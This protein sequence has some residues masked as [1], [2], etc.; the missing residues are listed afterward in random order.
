MKIIKNDYGDLKRRLWRFKA[1]TAISILFFLFNFLNFFSFLNCSYAVVPHLINYQGKLTDPTGKPVVDNTYS[2]TFKIYDNSA[3]NNPLWT[4][5]QSVP[6][7]KGIFSVMLGGVTPLNLTFEKQYYLG[8][9]V[10]QDAEMRPLQQLT[11]S[12]YA[13]RAE[14]ADNA[15]Q[16]QNANTITGIGVNATPASNKILPLDASAKLPAAALKSY[17]S[18]WFAVAKNTNYAKAHGLGTTKCLITV[19]IAQ[20]SDG[21][22]WCHSSYKIYVY[23]VAQ[24]AGTYVTALSTTSITIHTGYAYVA[25]AENNASGYTNGY[26]R[27]TMLALE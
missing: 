15:T 25:M 5:I 22:G 19:L 17:D 24:D 9:Q 3:G 14:N 16:A 8:I 13:F 26:A 23:G 20:N 21:S 4:E 12:G 18:G 11:S 7:Q 6:V 1:I 10:G 27:I 2:V